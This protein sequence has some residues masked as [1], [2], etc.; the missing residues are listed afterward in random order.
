V[1]KNVGREK[2]VIF[3][4]HIM[5]EV[6]AICDRVVI[7]NRGKLVA[8]SQRS[9]PRSQYQRPA[10]NHCRIRKTSRHERL[11]LEALPQVK[12]VKRTRRQSPTAS[13]FR[14]NRRSARA[15]VSQVSFTEQ[16]WGL[17]GL[18]QEENSLEKVFQQLTQQK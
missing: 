3:S 5:Q 10:R 16:N 17:I 13:Y 7:I 14:Q 4:T 15:A 6:A 11:M 2:T 9:R 1:I 18:R 12:E 8:D